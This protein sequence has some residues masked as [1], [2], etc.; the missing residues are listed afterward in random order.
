MVRKNYVSME[1]VIVSLTEDAI[2]T[3]EWV[4]KGESDFF[5]TGN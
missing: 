3:S 4:E 5:L 2:R 1:L